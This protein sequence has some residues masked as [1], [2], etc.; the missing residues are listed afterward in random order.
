MGALVSGLGA[1]Q[2]TLHPDDFDPQNY[3]RGVR[4]RLFAAFGDSLGFPLL[5]AR[6]CQHGPTLVVTANVHGDEY[7]GVRAILETFDSL[8]PRHLSAHL[9]A[10]PVVNGP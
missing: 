6:G 1:G 2:V 4:H 5:L 3:A 9:L 8:D 10:V 7:E